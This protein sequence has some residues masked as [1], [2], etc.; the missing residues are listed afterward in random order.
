MKFINEDFYANGNY[1]KK[2]TFVHFANYC[3]DVFS[4]PA[5]KFFLLNKLLALSNTEIQSIQIL[6]IKLFPKVHSIL[7]PV[8]DTIHLEKV[9]NVKRKME[10]KGIKRIKDQLRSSNNVM[11]INL[12]NKKKFQAIKER[13]KANQ[14]LEEGLLLYESEENSLEDMYIKEQKAN[15]GMKVSSKLTIYRLK[16]N[17]FRIN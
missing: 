2:E 1:Q 13:Y 7:D 17:F 4:R 11:Q 12:R 15:K 10:G 16:S 14:E 5:F 3:L 6:I 8:K 9:K